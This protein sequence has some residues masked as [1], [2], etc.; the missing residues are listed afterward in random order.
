MDLFLLLLRW[1]CVTSSSWKNIA[2]INS[3]Y[4]L[5]LT[6]SYLTYKNYF[7]AFTGLPVLTFTHEKENFDDMFN[8]ISK[9]LNQK[10]LIYLSLNHEDNFNG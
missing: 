6:V 10:C 5:L 1:Y 3:G 8:S 2:K 7:L 9:H 4:A